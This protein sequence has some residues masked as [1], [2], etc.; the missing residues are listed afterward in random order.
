M[1]QMDT[2]ML[3]GDNLLNRIAYNFSISQPS[4]KYDCVTVAFGPLRSIATC[5]IDANRIIGTIDVP[6]ENL[7]NINADSTE[8]LKWYEKILFIDDTNAILIDIQ[9][10]LGHIEMLK[11]PC[12]SFPN[13]EINVTRNDSIITLHVKTRRTINMYEPLTYSAFTP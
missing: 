4:N 12:T 6:V 10:K 5:N 8:G 13:C 3:F 11:E 7:I 9:L 1:A 2:E